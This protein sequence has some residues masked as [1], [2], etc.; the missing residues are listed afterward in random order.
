MEIFVRRND[1][2]FGPF[3]VREIRAKIEAGI[4]QRWD[5]ARIAGFDEWKTL[6]T[7]LSLGS[8][9]E[10]AYTLHYHACDLDSAIEMYN[11]IVSIHPETQEAYWAKEQLGMIKR[12]TPSER[13]SFEENFEADKLRRQREATKRAQAEAEKLRRQREATKRAQAEAEKLRRQREATEHAQAE[14]EKLRRQREAAER[15]EAENLR[16]QREA[17]EQRKRREADN[18]SAEA[19]TVVIDCPACAAKL[20]LPKA[21]AKLKVTCPKCEGKLEVRFAPSGHVHVYQ[22]AADKP[23]SSKV[24]DDPYVVL[25]V[26]RTATVEEI[27]RAFR[28]RMQEYH[29]DRVASLGIH[30]RALAEGE[31][32]RINR[33][34]EELLYQRSR[35]I[36]R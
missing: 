1:Q 15:A 33:A 9:L 4:F 6:D 35:N 34:C 8:L 12:M 24:E 18:A 25:Q 16:R 30:L 36:P 27:K 20:R 7:F 14:A 2:E 31:T 32:K 3:S 22:R 17:A 13:R 10:T 23:P 11:D 5:H 28:K 29:P 21:T 26:P 19:S